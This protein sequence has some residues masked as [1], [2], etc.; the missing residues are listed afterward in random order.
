MLLWT[1]QGVHQVW[2]LLA[3]ICKCPVSSQTIKYRYK[4]KLN[5][6]NLVTKNVCMDPLEV[7][8]KFQVSRISL[9]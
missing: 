3:D 6:K 1:P 8:T 2:S 7:C 5:Q 4:F 9:S